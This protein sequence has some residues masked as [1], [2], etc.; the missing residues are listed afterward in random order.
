LEILH[1]NFP[2]TPHGIRMGAYQGMHSVAQVIAPWLG[3]LLY[4][5]LGPNSFWGI[6][7]IIGVVSAASYLTLRRTQVL[8]D[9]PPVNRLA[10]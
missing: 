3:T 9:S 2:N 4:A 5:K 10:P 6:C 1:Q 7:G 8:A